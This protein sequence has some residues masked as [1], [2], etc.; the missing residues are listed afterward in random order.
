MRMRRWQKW[1]LYGAAGLALLL[2]VAAIALHTFFDGDKLKQMAQQR[3]AQAWGRELT[4]GAVTV[5]LLPTPHV[6]ARDVTLSNPAWA[7]EKQMFQASGLTAHF[8]LLPLLHGKPVVSS[9]QFDALRLNLE[10]DAEG[11]RNWLFP[12]NDKRAST[13]D[14]RHLHA[15]GSVVTWRDANGDRREWRVERLRMNSTGHLHDVAIETQIRR[16]D[17]LLELNGKFDDLSVFGETNATAK[18]LVNLRIGDAALVVDGTLPLD[19]ALQRYALAASIDARSLQ[20]AFSFFDIDARSPVPLKASGMLQGDGRRIDVK[21]FK[22]QMGALNLDADARL[23]RSGP[24]ARFDANVHADHVDMVQTFLDAGRPPLPAK[25][26]GQLFRDKPLPWPLLAGLS[27]VDGRV[28]AKIDSLKLR[29]GIQVTEAAAQLDL[30][31]DRMAVPSFSGKLLDGSASG[32]AVF[33]GKRQAVD[34]NLK[35]DNTLLSRWFKETNKKVPLSEGR[36]QVE[37]R[38]QAVGASLKTLAAS[39]T[40]PLDIR[41]AQMQVLSEKAGQAEFL[42]TGLLSAKDADRIDLSCI[43]ARLPFHNGIARGEA[44]AGARSDASQ[45]LTSGVVDMRTQTLDLRGRV[46]ARTGVALGWSSFGGNVKITGPIAKP[47]WQTDE[48]GKV[49]TIARI[50]AAILTSGA[51]IIVTSIWDGANPESDPCQQVFAAR[52][53]SKTDAGRNKTSTVRQPETTDA[54]N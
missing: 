7:K 30:H 25:E 37:M 41:I 2:A 53:G 16:N 22:L 8:A 5:S 17:T 6:R 43:S 36:M 42:L 48:A 9:L 32:D 15:D 21:D 34:L 51:S 1:G 12:T 28:D 10:T 14:L 50:G 27:N 19:P 31:D 40:G 13:L 33:E 54:P 4:I 18:G 46:R 11:R 39:A 49:G 47:K 44:I 24:R 20:P 29:N 35:L 23:D 52:H 45:L 38:V 3:A 26:E